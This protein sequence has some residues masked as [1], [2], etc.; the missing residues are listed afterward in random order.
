MKKLEIKETKTTQYSIFRTDQIKVGLVFP[1]SNFFINKMSLANIWMSLAA[2]IQ[3][4]REPFGPDLT[5]TSFD[6][7][8]D[9]RVLRS[10]CCITSS[11]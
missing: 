5:T 7:N 8:F 10:Y 9:Y 6:L 4:Q 11:N 1:I 2:V 3:L